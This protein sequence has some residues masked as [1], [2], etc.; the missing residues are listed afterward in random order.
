MGTLVLGSLL[1]RQ[2]VI[3]TFTAPPPQPLGS[4]SSPVHFHLKEQ[5]TLFW[6]VIRTW[7]ATL[8]QP[9]VYAAPV[10]DAEPK[11]MHVNEGS[12]VTLHANA[13]VVQPGDNGN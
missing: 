7:L 13:N 9:T 5:I 2:E 12:V 1:T 10:A 6:A 4:L 11:D 3:E 8:S